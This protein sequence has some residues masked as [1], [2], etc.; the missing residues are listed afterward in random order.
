MVNVHANIKVSFFLIDR[1]WLFPL[2]SNENQTESTKILFVSMGG[3]RIKISYVSSYFYCSYTILSFPL[4]KH[5]GQITCNPLWNNTPDLVSFA[6]STYVYV[7]YNSK[8]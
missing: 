4:R 7:I 5:K 2:C 6:E 3:G 1:E 8:G